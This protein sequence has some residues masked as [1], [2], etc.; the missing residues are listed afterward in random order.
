MRLY[1]M[2][3]A[4]AES[5]PLNSASAVQEHPDL[6]ISEQNQ[7]FRADVSDSNSNQIFLLVQIKPADADAKILDYLTE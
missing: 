1:P 4:Q 7:N 2:L 6:K 5:L 3:S